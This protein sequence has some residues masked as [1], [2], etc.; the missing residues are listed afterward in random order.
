MVS[1]RLLHYKI[2]LFPFVINNYV[3]RYFEIMQI[4]HSSLKFQFIHFC[5]HGVMVSYF[6]SMGYKLLLSLFILKFKLPLI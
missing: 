3:R 1:A 6:Y 5:Q 2:T 4:S